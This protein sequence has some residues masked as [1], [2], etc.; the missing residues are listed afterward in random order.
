MSDFSIQVAMYKKLT[1]IGQ[2]T[3]LIQHA[4]L[5][6]TEQHYLKQKQVAIQCTN[7]LKQYKYDIYE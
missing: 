3:S 6:H 4:A 5:G 7:K 2:S 1:I